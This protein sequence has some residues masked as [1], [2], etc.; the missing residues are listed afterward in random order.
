[1]SAV[2][3]AVLVLC[4]ALLS[5][6]LHAGGTR[7]EANGID[8]ETENAL[9][10]LKPLLQEAAKARI[11]HLVSVTPMNED[12]MHRGRL[13]L[14]RALH[15][16]AGYDVLVL[17]IGTF[18]GARLEAALANGTAPDKAAAT[19]YKVWRQSPDF[20]NILGYVNETREP[21]EPMEIIGGLCRYH[22]A[23]KRLYGPYVVALFDEVDPELIDAAMRGKIDSV[24]SINNR[25]SRATPEVRQEAAQLAEALLTRF[26]HSRDAFV[27]TY[28]ERRVDLE[29]QF[30][31]NMATFVELEKIRGG[32]G[33]GEDDGSV[34]RREKRQ[35]LS[36]LLGHYPGK[37]LIYWEARGPA[38]Q[39][40]LPT[41]EQVFRVELVIE[42]DADE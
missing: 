15:E 33:G 36:W 28:G 21:S 17:P 1:V 40:D 42:V 22:M 20:Q 39:P 24:W 5:A 13:T 4:A 8:I 12:R 35:N 3:F 7:L 38:P 26:D 9:D 18:E 10:R 11:L 31:V 14:I 27:E 41:D 32:E 37:K 25:L 16:N 30:L 23:A 34:A 29:R 6:S 19:V 2:R